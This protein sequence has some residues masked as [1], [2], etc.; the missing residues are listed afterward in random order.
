MLTLETFFSDKNKFTWENCE[1]NLT[2]M[3]IVPNYLA[4]SNNFSKIFRSIL[5]RISHIIS[6]NFSNS[7]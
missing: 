5:Q 7:I 1:G 6:L 2:L 3:R 4:N